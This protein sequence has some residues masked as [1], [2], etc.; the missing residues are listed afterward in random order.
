MVISVV[1]FRSNQPAE[2]AQRHRGPQQE[3]RER[4]ARERGRDL[5]LRVPVA[6]LRAEL[7]VDLPQPEGRGR[8]E[9]P[10]S[11]LACDPGERSRIRWN[12]LGPGPAFAA[13]RRV[14][15]TSVAVI[16]PETS[17]ASI[18]DA[19]STGTAT[20]RCGLAAATTRVASAS[21]TASIGRWRRQPG[22]RGTTEGWSAGVANAAASAR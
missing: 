1:S 12:A 16:E 7:V 21:R 4:A 2:P 18:T 20:V 8:R 6:E 11:G 17:V 14:G 15:F 19:C 22:R 10:A 13:D 9:A 3:E 5:P